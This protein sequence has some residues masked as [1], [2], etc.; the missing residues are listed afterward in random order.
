MG[1]S[2]LAAARRLGE[3]GADVVALDAVGV[4][5]GAAGRNGGF[6]LVGGARFHHEAVATW[7]HELAVGLYRA[8]IDELERTLS[9]L[10]PLAR[11]TGSLR[12]AASP[13]EERDIARQLRALASDGLVGEAYD[14]PEG[15]GLLVPDDAVLQ[16]V[17]RC[18]HLAQ[19]AADAGVRL[20][21][22]ARVTGLGEGAVTTTAGVVRAGRT[23]VAVD[24]GLERLLPELAAEVGTARLQMLATSPDPGLHLPRPVYRRWG[25]DYVQ[26]LPTGEL[27][28]GGC[29]DRS[30][31][32]EWDAP[33]VPSDEVQACLDAELVRL[34][35]TAPVTHRWAAHAAFTGD[36]LPV[37]REVRPGVLVVGAYSGHGNLLG[38]RCGRAAA[39]AALDGT[40]LGLEG[41]VA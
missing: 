25:Y 20:H 39:D 28:L 24:G 15:R 22:P 19:L 41:V 33:A 4:A 34:G 17:A 10:G 5:A 35:A 21:A 30:A 1:A 38:T 29:R 18:R 7:G 27:L 12:I 2:G 26:Q 36:A 16:P 9:D 6:L 11:R 8:T 13:D 14:G 23:V 31:A 40:R 32:A 3:R 37:C